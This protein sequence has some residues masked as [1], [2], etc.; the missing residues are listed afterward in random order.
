MPPENYM[1][2]VVEVMTP[3]DTGEVDALGR[4]IV[5]AGAPTTHRGR[6]V[7]HET[8]DYQPTVDGR[9]T[10]QYRLFLPAGAV[11]APGDTVTI[12]DRTFT[13]VDAVIAARAPATPIGYNVVTV[14]E[15]T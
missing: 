6:L 12:A 1:T 4:P 14:R 2:D 10:A 5:A 11:V 9:V 8:P 15:V 7:V 3:L 13:L